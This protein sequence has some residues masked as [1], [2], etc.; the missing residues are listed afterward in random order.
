MFSYVTSL[1][2][3]VFDSVST[4]QHEHKMALLL[5]GVLLCKCLSYTSLY[6]CHDKYWIVVLQRNTIDRHK[7]P[8][9]GVLCRKMKQKLAIV[10]RNESICT[11]RKKYASEISHCNSK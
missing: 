2:T 10:K 6:R 5:N 11:D 9:T 8:E 3:V 7:L 1:I 4:F